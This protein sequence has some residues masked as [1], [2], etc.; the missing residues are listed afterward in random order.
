MEDNKKQIHI[1]KLSLTKSEQ[2]EIRPVDTDAAAASTSGD[3]FDPQEFTSV[4]AD[5]SISCCLE[6]SFKLESSTPTTPPVMF[7]DAPEDAF[8]LSSEGGTHC[9]LRCDEVDELQE[10]RQRRKQ[11]E[12]TRNILQKQWR[13]LAERLSLEGLTFPAVPPTIATED[14]ISDPA[15][16]LCQQIS[17]AHAV[18]FSIGMEAAKAEG[19]MVLESK[20]KEKD[21]EIS[22]LKQR[23]R[24]HEVI[25][26]EISLRNQEAV[27]VERIPR[28]RKKRRHR[29]IWSSFGVSVVVGS[30]ALAWFFLKADSGSLSPM[31]TLSAHVDECLE[32]DVRD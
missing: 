24:Y 3:L 29:W 22:R 21:F 6:R 7:F 27:G 18:S 17:L 8:E 32:S 19:E 16:D 31:G 20:I 13:R 2:L 4:D 30:M 11:A 1:P 25:N 9:S 15:G 28:Q 10:E 14:E 12:E 23:L 26:H 5:D